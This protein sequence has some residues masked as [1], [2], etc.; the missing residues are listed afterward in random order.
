MTLLAI[1]LAAQ[2]ATP[3]VT[4]AQRRNTLVAGLPTPMT[5][6]VPTGDG[7]AYARCTTTAQRILWTST[8][9]ETPIPQVVHRGYVYCVGGCPTPTDQEVTP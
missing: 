1:L 3:T 7:S 5:R 4:E 6:C 8:S 2:A 9:D